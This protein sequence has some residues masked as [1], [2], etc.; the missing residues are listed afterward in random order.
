MPNGRPKE[1]LSDV[2]NLAEEK[3]DELMNEFLMDYKEGSHEAKGWPLANSAYIVSKAAVNA[4][5]RVLAKKYSCFGINA[6]SPG[7]IKTDMNGGNGALTSDEGAEPIVKLALLKDGS[8]S[9]CFF[10]RGEEKSF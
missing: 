10:S 6:I 7:Y 8:P 9:G 5:T 4:Y 3:I 1:V 2:E